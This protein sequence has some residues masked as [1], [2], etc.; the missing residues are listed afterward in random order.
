MRAKESCVSLSAW[1]LVLLHRQAATCNPQHK[2]HGT[3][4]ARLQ[5]LQ[6]K[7]CCPAAFSL[8]VGLTARL[9]QLDSSTDTLCLR[10]LT[11]PSCRSRDFPQLRATW[12][13][14]LC[15]SSTAHRRASESGHAEARRRDCMRACFE[16]S[17]IG[18]GRAK[19]DEHA[20]DSVKLPPTAQ[21]DHRRGAPLLCTSPRLPSP[22]F[23]RPS[24]ID[25]L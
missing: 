21:P 24:F 22:L 16:P 25:L 8:L 12:L 5:R 23:P 3:A 7:H 18:V 10:L 17:R 2:L 6:E 4:T 15:A 9:V 20:A 11:T 14:F 1:L 19:Q 13:T